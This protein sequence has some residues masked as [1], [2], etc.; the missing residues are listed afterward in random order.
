MSSFKKN[1]R[2]SITP[3]PPGTRRFIGSQLLT[4]TG[5]AQIDEILGG[6]VLCGSMILLEEDAGSTAPVSS[7]SKTKNIHHSSRNSIGSLH[8]LT[9][10]QLF[11]AEG[12]ACGHRVCVAG[13]NGRIT[14]SAFLGSLPLNISQDSLDV[15]AALKK[16]QEN[17]QQSSNSSDSTSDLSSDSTS[18]AQ[19]EDKV[20]SGL[21]NAWQYKKYLPAAVP[22]FKESSNPPSIPNVSNQTVS[23]PVK[24]CHTFDLERNIRADVLTSSEAIILP[25]VSDTMHFSI[26]LPPKSSFSSSKNTQLSPILSS[27]VRDVSITDAVLLAQSRSSKLS[28]EEDAIAVAHARA[29]SDFYDLR[30]SSS[31]SSTTENGTLVYSSL[32]H[33]VRTSALLIPFNEASSS[34]NDM[35][36][37]SAKPVIFETTPPHEIKRRSS[38]TPLSSRSTGALPPPIPNHSESNRIS[39]QNDVPLSPLPALRA[40]AVASPL[41]LSLNSSSTLPLSSSSSLSTL[42]PSTRT[43]SRIVLLGLGGP[44]WPGFCGSDAVASAVI[45][46]SAGL[47]H[48]N[49]FNSYRPLFRFLSNLR[50]SLD[51]QRL[52]STTSSVILVTMPTWCMPLTVSAHIRKLFDVVFKLHAFDDPEYA[53]ATSRVDAKVFTST[54]AAS[55]AP[56]FKDYTGMLIIRRLPRGA[57]ITG[58]SV[59]SA[60]VAATPANLPDTLT[61]AMRREKRKLVIERPHLPPAEEETQQSQQGTS[62]STSSSASASASASVSDKIS[63][64]TRVSFLNED[65]DDIKNVASTTPLEPGMSCKASASNGGVSLLDF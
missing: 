29:L 13:T 52:T 18:N 40:K 51:Q 24:Y 59:T 61:W 5:H 28:E 58:G 20:G 33:H 17:N 50:A 19:S 56:E 21:I 57:I 39:S 53:L 44:L 46:G 55:T 45:S 63:Q 15:Q 31:S 41:P 36:N 49:I 47:A 42:A 8:S 7:S 14:P 48:E 9:L 23:T 12:I 26:K 4:S 62:S 25:S 38:I 1:I 6:G 16:V 64:H 30:N 35:Y 3:E 10:A 32:F 43:I 34:S 22:V 37:D 11:A 54:V 2:V 65:N 27:S 60:A